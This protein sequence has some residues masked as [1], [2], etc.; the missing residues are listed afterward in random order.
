M[1]GCRG[2]LGSWRE[3]EGKDTA[4]LSSPL[5]WEAELTLHGNGKDADGTQCSLPL[6]GVSVLITVV[7]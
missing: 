6:E 4:E 1:V 7:H 2:L 3:G 5:V